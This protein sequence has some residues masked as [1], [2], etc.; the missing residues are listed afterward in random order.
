MSALGITEY[1]EKPPGSDINKVAQ[2]LFMKEV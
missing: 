1:E 2:D